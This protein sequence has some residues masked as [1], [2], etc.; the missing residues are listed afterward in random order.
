MIVTIDEAK[1]ITNG[2]HLAASATCNDYSGKSADIKPY[3][4]RYGSGYTVTSGKVKKYYVH[5]K[6]VVSERVYRGGYSVADACMTANNVH[7]V[8]YNGVSV[9]PCWQLELDTVTGDYVFKRTETLLPVTLAGR[10]LIVTWQGSMQNKVLR[11][12]I[13]RKM[14][15]MINSGKAVF[16]NNENS[17]C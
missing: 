15:E 11:A 5:S 17:V 8:K 1:K 16:F 10:T 2:L 13:R 7:V 6:N 4:G 9:T 12:K 14:R 3:F